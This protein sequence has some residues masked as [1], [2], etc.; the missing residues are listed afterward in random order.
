MDQIGALKA[1]RPD[2]MSAIF[3]HHYWEKV[4]TGLTEMVI[5]FFRTGFMLK[6]KQP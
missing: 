2:G 3:Y 4:Q 6:K 1:P 5:H